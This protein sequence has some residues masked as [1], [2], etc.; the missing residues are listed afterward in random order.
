MDVFA[1][2]LYGITVCSKTG[3]AGGRAGSGKKRFIE[4][5]TLWIAGLFSLLPDMISM[6][7]PFLLFLFGDRQDNFFHEFTDKNIVLYRYMHSLVLSLGVFG[8]IAVIR[9]SWAI[10]A[11]AWSVHVICDSVTHDA[12]KFRTTLFYPFTDWGFDGFAFWI[13]L[14]A[15]IVYWSVLPVVWILLCR[16]RR[17]S[18]STVS[19]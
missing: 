3:L 17:T 10:P 16:Y 4:D 13:D 1:H 6:W 7:L 9:R 11:L 5:S 15:L 18:N 8:L 12:G 19:L 2:S 14:R